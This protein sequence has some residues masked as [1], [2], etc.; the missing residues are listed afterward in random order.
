ML[1]SPI[2][3]SVIYGKKY[4][5]MFQKVSSFFRRRFFNKNV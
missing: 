1:A 5:E 4:A 2:P 3:V